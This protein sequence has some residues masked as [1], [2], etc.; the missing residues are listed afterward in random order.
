MGCSDGCSSVVEG[1][2]LGGWTKDEVGV[3]GSMLLVV[4]GVVGGMLL[5]V[6]GMVDDDGDC[7]VGYEAI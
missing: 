5:L 7:G 6:L 2:V 4:L 1:E 3:V